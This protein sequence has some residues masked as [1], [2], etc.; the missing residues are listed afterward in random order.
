VTDT[1]VFRLSQPRTF[2]DPLTEVLRNGARVL[3]AQAVEAEV[4]A[5]LAGH[6]DK[7]T[8]DGRQRSSLRPPRKADVASMVA[9]SCRKSSSV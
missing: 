7:L 8:D 1:N 3:L 9:I 2:S 6:A 4:S 5:L